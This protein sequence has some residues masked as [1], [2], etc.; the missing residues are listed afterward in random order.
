MRAQL[1]GVLLKCSGDAVFSTVPGLGESVSVKSIT[2]EDKTAVLAGKALPGEPP[3]TQLKQE[4][5][6]QYCPLLPILAGYV[7]HVR[8]KV[9]NQKRFRGQEPTGDEFGD[10]VFQYGC[11]LVGRVLPGFARIVKVKIPLVP[12]ADGS[13][14]SDEWDRAIAKP[15]LDKV[16]CEDPDYAESHKSDCKASAQ[17][18]LPALQAKTIEV[19]LCSVTHRQ[20]D[21]TL[22]KDIGLLVSAKGLV[23][24]PK[25]AEERPEQVVPIRPISETVPW[26]SDREIEQLKQSAIRD[27]KLA[28]GTALD[29]IRKIH[30]QGPLGVCRRYGGVEVVAGEGALLSATGSVQPNAYALRRAAMT[31]Y[32]CKTS[33]N[34]STLIH[35]K[36]VGVKSPPC[37]EPRFMLMQPVTLARPSTS[38]KPAAGGVIKPIA[39][40][41]VTMAIAKVPFHCRPDWDAECRRVY[42]KLGVPMEAILGP[43]EIEC[44]VQAQVRESIAM[45]LLFNKDLSVFDKTQEG[46]HL[47]QVVLRLLG[48]YRKAGYLRVF[49]NAMAHHGAKIKVDPSEAPPGDAQ[50]EVKI[51]ND[52]AVHRNR[53]ELLRRAVDQ[54]TDGYEYTR[55]TDF[56]QQSSSFGQLLK[57]LYKRGEGVKVQKFWDDC[58]ELNATCENPQ[59]EKEREACKRCAEAAFTSGCAGKGKPDDCGGGLLTYQ[60][61][62]SDPGVKKQ[63]NYNAMYNT[64]RNWIQTKL[65]EEAHIEDMWVGRPQVSNQEI[66]KFV[67]LQYFLAPPNAGGDRRFTGEGKRYLDALPISAWQRCYLW[68]PE[69]RRSGSRPTEFECDKPDD[70]RAKRPDPEANP[71]GFKH[72]LNGTPWHEA[73][74]FKLVFGDPRLGGQLVRDIQGEIA[75]KKAAR[76]AYCRSVSRTGWSCNMSDDGDPNSEACKQAAVERRN[77]KDPNYLL[78]AADARI[79]AVTG[80]ASSDTAQLGIEGDSPLKEAGGAI[81]SGIMP[82]VGKLLGLVLKAEGMAETMKMLAR[83]AGLTPEQAVDCEDPEYRREQMKLPK[84]EDNK[85]GCLLKVFAKNFSGALESIVIMLGNK[86]VDWAV[87]ALRALLQGVK[88]AIITV[89]GSVPFAGGFL[90]ALV[91]IAWELL[92]NYGAK[93]LLKALVV[94]QLPKWLKIKE[95]ARLP[96]EEVIQIPVVN[97]VSGIIIELIEAAVQYGSQNWTA[98]GFASVLT[99]AQRLLADAREFFWVRVLAVA[100]KEMAKEQ[101]KE[102]IVE[103]LRE[104]V[105]GMVEG[106]A[107]AV[108]QRLDPRLREAF[109]KSVARIKEYVRNSEK[110]E[111][112]KKCFTTTPVTCMTNLFKDT[113][114]PAVLA[115]V[116]AY[117]QMPSWVKELLIALATELESP[118]IAARSREAILGIIANAVKQFL[119]DLTERV[120]GSGEG[121]SAKEFVNGLRAGVV[122]ALQSPT[123]LHAATE[124]AALFDALCEKLKTFLNAEVDVVF[125]GLAEKET[126]KTGLSNLF[127]ILRSRRW[128][129]ATAENAKTALALSSGPIVQS[130]RSAAIRNLIGGAIDVLND[131]L[132]GQAPTQPLNPTDV[133]NKLLTGPIKDFIRELLPIP[134][135]DV[136]WVTLRDKLLDGVTD[137]PSLS[138][139]VNTFANNRPENRDAIKARVGKLVDGLLRGMTDKVESRA[140]KAV[141][142][143]AA[144]SL[145]T[146][147]MNPQDSR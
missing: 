146:Y 55:M 141:V 106:F 14:G 77:C 121:A 72:Y 118:A 132:S 24:V 23:R 76:D 9:A 84:A 92:M 137:L 134:G 78:A 56:L 33:T 105:A 142:N 7:D 113:L 58:S 4:E 75:R 45:N 143:A 91:D 147:I 117:V 98:I 60:Y 47:D 26:S 95:L 12:G 124:P 125:A 22:R 17:V 10:A 36:P 69:R 59:W 53:R 3:P 13:D 27:A 48:F 129:S 87:D 79:A 128:D 52:S 37:L 122:R 81:Q 86:L 93:T 20:L 112:L 11:R 100:R 120:L 133:V 144:D 18:V 8:E 19:E 103:Q 139:L 119:P 25:T 32:V 136:V 2:D 114:G 82:I 42:E 116:V 61:R 57:A 65:I 88:T 109:G 41:T 110:L 66:A 85:R 39:S 51:Q 44:A 29:A 28:D 43:T 108:R 127:N 83:A 145:K 30:P 80:E 54:W 46:N 101:P 38:G 140:L 1:A 35:P 73:P 104:L 40:G 68:T 49:S 96:F 67:V 123:A 126:I 50:N 90:A 107:E 131:L 94:T 135:G 31:G 62:W 99:A 71:Q 130:I 89:A 70:E 64:F 63:A 115:I 15:D 16:K 6:D 21:R 102:Q 138:A 111:D 5:F 74:L 97:V 34:V